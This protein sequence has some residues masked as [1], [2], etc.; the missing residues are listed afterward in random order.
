MSSDDGAIDGFATT[1]ALLAQFEADAAAGGAGVQGL[2]GRLMDRLSFSSRASG[3]QTYWDPNLVSQ[4]RTAL[5]SSLH[6]FG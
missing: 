5:D 4:V 2:E 3:I 6:C 1:P